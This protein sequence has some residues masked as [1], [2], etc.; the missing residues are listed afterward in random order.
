MSKDLE[1]PINATQACEKLG[2]GNARM[3]AVKKAMGIG[4]AR[5]FFL[6]DVLKFTRA[7]PSFQIRDVYPRKNGDKSSVS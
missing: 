6:S 5:Y 3:S 4:G 2:W 7:N 1:I